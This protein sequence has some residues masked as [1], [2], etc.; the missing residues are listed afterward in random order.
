MSRV[1]QVVIV[2][3]GATA[4]IT[5]LGLQRAIGRSGVDVRVVEL[6]SSPDAMGADAMGPDAMGVVVALPSLAGLHALLGLD[7]ATV[8][9]R[10]RGVPMLGQ[11]FVG[12]SGGPDA[13]VHAYDVQRPAIDDIDFLQFWVKARGKGL[14]VPLEEFSLAAAA[15]KQGR[16]SDL[17]GGRETLA[18]FTPGYHLDAS[19]YAAL[20]KAAAI[21]AGVTRVATAR[22]SVERR[23]DRIA[24]VT[25]DDATRLEGDLFVDASGSDAVLMKHAERTSWRH[26]LGCDRVIAMSG[27]PLRTLP[28]YGQ[29]SAFDT[30]WIGLFPLRDRIALIAAC[31]AQGRSDEELVER[32]TGLAGI[33]LG[34]DALVSRFEAGALTRPWTGNCVA[35]GEA[36]V[37]LEPLDAVQPQIV[38]IGLSNLIALWPANAEAML[39]AQPYNDAVASHIANLRDFQLAHYAL[40]RR[41][42][43]PWWDRARAAPLPERLAEKLSLFA[44]RGQVP[45]HDDESFASQNWSASFVGHG[46]IPRGYDPRVDKVPDVEQI[47]KITALLHVIAD[48]VA[49][50]PTVEQFLARRVV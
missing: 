36:A 10:C 41:V 22:V 40:N 37:A 31:A 50:M 29:V 11:R 43:E 16:M 4:W 44:A 7:D 28:A 15:A 1:R 9:E 8:F 20:L 3:R 35:I 24:S 42:G 2:G 30:G 33:R 49:A 23:D 13:F 5:A 32:V 17:A 14:R 25:L 45:L 21:D 27:P 18:G 26:W 19:S 48:E 12:W 46:V 39:E 6:P 47:G 34:A 38:Q